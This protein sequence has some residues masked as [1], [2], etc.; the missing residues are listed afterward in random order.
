MGSIF[1]NDESKIIS[2]KGE[3]I[4]SDPEK[5]NEVMNQYRKYKE[6]GRHGDFMFDL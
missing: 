1:D 4:L 6:E 2:K 3:Q 5:M